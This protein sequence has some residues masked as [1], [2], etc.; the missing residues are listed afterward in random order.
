[1]KKQLTSVV[2]FLFFLGLAA[3]LVWLAIKDKTSEELSN[4]REA[5]RQADYFWILL[6]VV[7]SGLSHYFRALRWKMLLKPL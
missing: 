4:I 6:S 1:M 7:I 3:L 5:I 2:K